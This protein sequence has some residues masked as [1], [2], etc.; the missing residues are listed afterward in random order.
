MAFGIGWGRSGFMDDMG[1]A[2][3]YGWI[4]APPIAAAYF[5]WLLCDGRL[6]TYAPR[7]LALAVL[8]FAPVNVI[9]G[10][11][12][13]EKKIRPF[14]AAWE[15]DVRAGHMADEVVSRTLARRTSGPLRREIANTMR[16]M[17]DHGYTYYGSLGRE[18]P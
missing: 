7:L 1:F 12:D 13:A 11:R 18:A 4:T 3:R 14:E 15:A 2:W 17:R 9:S 10:F 16:L 6:A 5:T 8:V